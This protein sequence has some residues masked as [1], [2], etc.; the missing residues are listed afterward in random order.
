[1][2][3]NPPLLRG[4][5]ASFC[6]SFITS[7]STQIVIRFTVMTTSYLVS[8]ITTPCSIGEQQRRQYLEPAAIHASG[9]VELAH[10]MR[11]LSDNPQVNMPEDKRRTLNPNRKESRHILRQDLGRSVWPN[12]Q[13]SFHE[14]DR[15][16][17]VASICHEGLE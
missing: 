11:P 9:E 10:G 1:M 14:T 7:V 8:T 15:D 6:R 3:K 13:C 12:S 5:S 16:L 4:G 17:V 2:L